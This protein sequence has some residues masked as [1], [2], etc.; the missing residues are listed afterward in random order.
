MVVTV[1]DQPMVN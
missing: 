1:S